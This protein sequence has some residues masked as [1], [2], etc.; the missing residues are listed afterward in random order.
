MKK[1]NLIILLSIFISISLVSAQISFCCERLEN[2]A[3]CQNA[4]EEECNEN[5]LSAP[6]SCEATSYCR[7]GT[8]INTNEGICMSNTPERVC[9]DA[10]GVWDERDSSEIPQCQLG[11]CLI[12]EQAAF[13]TLTKCK[14]L[15]SVYGLEIDYRTDIKNEMSCIAMASPDVKG[16][17]VYEE[18]FQRNCKMTTKDECQKMQ[19]EDQNVEFHEGY[20]CSAESLETICGPRGG[21]TC[22]EGKDEVYFLDTCGNLAN[23]YNNNLI[24][25]ALYW[26]Q[27]MAP[28]CS[29][30]EDGVENCGDCDYLAGTVCKEAERGNSP[31]YGNYI[32]RDLGCE[33]EAFR[34][35]YGR[36]PEHGETWCA[37]T[38]RDDL[39]IGQNLGIIGDDV[40]NLVN[41]GNNPGSRDA[42][43][44]C[45]NG[46]VTVE[47]CADYRQEIC[48]NS[49]VNGFQTA[50]CRVNMWEDCYSQ[51]NPTD[52]E[53]I[54]KRDC[55]W[56]EGV[57]ILK[58]EEGKGL[59]LDVNNQ[60]VSSSSET[61]FRIENDN[62]VEAS[63]IPRY[64]P[65]FDFWEEGTDATN[66]CSLASTTCYVEY[67]AGIAGGG[68]VGKTN[69]ALDARCMEK[70]RSECLINDPINLCNSKCE[71][72][73]PSECVQD[74]GTIRQEWLENMNI[75]C[76][77]MGDCGMSMNYIGQEGYYTEPEDFVTR[78]SGEDIKNE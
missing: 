26:E 60:L 20:L 37:R 40:T 11:C 43:L 74:D 12:G 52:C 65:G 31:E 33:D 15:S 72:E 24:D 68:L 21:T 30:D 41:G 5:Y 70:C 51:T 4:P 67:A 3:W 8:C 34:E 71:K 66:L 77:A 9:V 22:V 14:S 73:C 53:N 16:A 18:E 6:T 62:Y 17:C 19:N 46:E 42:R 56:V 36:N 2:G 29:V 54:D 58:D 39:V 50:G 35:E 23:V 45:Y 75:I 44:L 55:A 32:C 61:D 38:I 27:L 78:S 63:C 13:T 69:K 10:D 76:S 28:E 48:I 64:A 47:P 49:E 57:S 25:D 1:I 59:V 7:L